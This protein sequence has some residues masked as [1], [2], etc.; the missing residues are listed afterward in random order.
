MKRT[1]LFAAVLLCSTV[2]YA[3]N[4]HG[5]DVSTTA[6][7]TTEVK[8]GKGAT[9]SENASIKAKDK[10]AVEARKAALKAKIEARKEG[11]KELT[12][13]QKAEIEARKAALKAKIEARKEAHKELTAEQKIEIAARKEALKVKIA[14]RKA[15]IKAK[16]RVTDP[17]ASVVRPKIR[18]KANVGLKV[19]G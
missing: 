13:E 2:T 1:V 5:V 10:E 3:Q 6:K 7:T 9:I 17:G 19:R 18:A 14:E 4:E 15:E 8:R 12:A 11:R 16:P